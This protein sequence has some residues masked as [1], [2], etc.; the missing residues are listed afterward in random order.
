LD[1]IPGAAQSPSLDP[2]LEQFRE[3]KRQFCF[4]TGF[5]W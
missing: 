3:G 2:N 1:A 4:F 5:R